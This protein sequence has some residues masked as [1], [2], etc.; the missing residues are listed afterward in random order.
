MQAILIL[1]GI[2][3]LTSPVHAE[4][5]DNFR[6]RLVQQAP[7]H[8]LSAD[9]VR[10]ELA[11]VK[12]H[13][14]IIE[15]DRA[16]STEY[17]GRRLTWPEYRSR[18]VTP[19]RIRQGRAMMAEHHALLTHVGHHYGVPPQYIV[20]LWGVE[21]SYGKNTG[22]FDVIQALATLAWEGRRREFFTDEL[23]KALRILQEGHISRP[24]FKGSWAGAMGQNQFMPSSFYRYAVDW[25]KDGTRDIWRAQGDVFASTA[26]Y[27]KSEGWNGTIRWGR[28][29]KLTKPLPSSLVGLEV[30]KPL[31]FWAKYGI[32]MA[33]G[34]AL[35]TENVDSSILMPDGLD[36]PVFLVYDNFRTIMEWNRS[37]N[38][39]LSVGH[40]ADAL[41]NGN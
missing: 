4:S 39:A 29:V 13:A 9:F 2:F 15:L 5:F 31:S 30:R 35:P 24:A 17:G 21:T 1:F 11:D 7:Q 33:N 6:Q 20:A 25:T 40:L 38:F 22:G 14:R 27:L 32:T 28:E 10:Q 36:G 26:N 37:T 23:F 41:A 16:Q 8:G 12:P 3:I 18:I 34:N 19:A